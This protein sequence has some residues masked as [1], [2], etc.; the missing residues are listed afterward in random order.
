[1]SISAI[2]E[3]S[4]VVA[5]NLE[6][7]SEFVIIV[8]HGGRL[9]PRRLGD[10]GLPDRE[11][12]RHIA[13]DIGA[14]AVAESLAAKLEAPMI[15]QA[16]SRLVID[17]N[18]DPE[19]ASSIPPV[20]EYTEIPGNASLT[21]EEVAAR[22][23]EIFDPY[24]GAIGMLLDR[25]RDQGLRTILVAQHSMTDLYKGER[26]E[27]HAAILYN[28]DPRFA[29]LLRDILLQE[30]GLIVADNQP[31][32]LSDLTD[33][34]IPHHGERRGLPHVEIEIRQDL[35]SSPAGQREWGARLA[36]ALRRAADQFW[37]ANPSD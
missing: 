26:R 8:D 4:P 20:S 29:V 15:A 17:C 37:I 21:A 6:S 14:Q 18:R 25:R 9:I 12:G 30:E 7:R 32:F 31:Y 36:L 13:W 34:S 1:M 16:Y 28:R 5:A 24:H 11:L 27:M 2:D 19:V 3:P 33:Y 10:L 35:I 22:R 23:R